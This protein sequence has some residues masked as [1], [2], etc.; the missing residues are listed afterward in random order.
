MRL[1]E[2]DITQRCISLVGFSDKSRNMIRETI[3][4]VY[5]E[6]VNMYTKFLILDSPSVYN[7]ILGQ[8]WIHMMEA[9][10]STYHQIL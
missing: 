4:P 9:I 10:P 1:E 2:K 3:L 7:V 8:S 5:V 6:G